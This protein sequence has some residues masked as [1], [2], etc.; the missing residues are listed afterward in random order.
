MAIGPSVPSRKPKRIPLAQTP[1]TQID[2]LTNAV[3]T[4]V[5]FGQ[6]VVVP[7]I[8]QTTQ[9]ILR[10]KSSLIDT[11]K[12]LALER[13]PH[14]DDIRAAQDRLFNLEQNPEI[15]NRVLGLFDPDFN[16]DSQI[17]KM[18]SGKF[19]LNQITNRMVEAEALHG[20]EVGM[21]KTA[22][23]GT[24]SFYSFTREGNL[25]VQNAILVGFDIREGVRKEQVNLVESTTKEQLQK[26]EQNPDKMPPKLRGLEQLVTAELFQREVK[27]KQLNALDISTTIAEQSLFAAQRE[28]Y[29]DQF[30][31][32][33][34]INQAKAKFK[35]DPNSAPSYISDNHF[36]EEMQNRNMISL[37]FRSA[38]NAVDASDVQLRDLHVARAFARTSETDLRTALKNMGDSKTL[39]IMPGVV[40]TKEELSSAIQSKKEVNFKRRQANAELLATIV[41]TEESKN[42]ALNGALMLGQMNNPGGDP[43]Q[44]IPGTL[45]A[46]IQ[47]AQNIDTMLTPFTDAGSVP[48]AI[49]KS[50]A[51][52]VV[53][54]KVEA[55]IKSAVDNAERSDKAGINSYLR[56]EGRMTSGAVSYGYAN[57]GNEFALSYDP[58]LGPGA[59]L[60]AQEL[61]D[62]IGTQ[63]FSFAQSETEL[64]FDSNE[65]EKQTRL[66]QAVVDSNVRQHVSDS[67]FQF[68]LQSTLQKLV[69]S[70]ATGPNEEPGY[71]PDSPYAP[72]IA[73]NGTLS[74]SMYNFAD[75]QKTFM[76][77]NFYKALASAQLRGET[78]GILQPGNELSVPVIDMMREMAPGLN[79]RF[80]LSPHAAALREV[81]FPNGIQGGIYE[82]L[83]K[84]SQAVPSIIENM[85]LQ[86]DAMREA[87]KQEVENEMQVP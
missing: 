5:E 58:I 47:T 48:D 34:Q 36:D 68:L 69:F 13:E 33:E 74:A 24:Q 1:T 64:S 59:Q 32:L 71:D 41:G 31:T 70:K 55:K 16:R 53:D 42:N 77:G 54:D 85:Q 30:D 84:L 63:S 76:Y 61:N 12:A 75:S 60:Y 66:N 14:R 40:I 50:K 82:R 29:F 20:L 80:S 18:Q 39:A 21:A 19:E 17:R 35:A 72:L 26:W 65:K 78:N 56:N 57:L 28:S 49:V 27:E 52:K 37:E 43:G 2:A 6:R 22:L 62:I 15:V 86:K 45:R 10:A 9:E 87:I 83:S 46:G 25:D 44:G 3:M 38:R 73:S 51:W 79:N 67:G 81:A 7:A 4:N 23:A 11:T 8:K